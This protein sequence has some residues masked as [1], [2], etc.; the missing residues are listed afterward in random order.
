MKGNVITHN[1]S[2]RTF[3]EMVWDDHLAVKGEGGSADLIH[4]YPH[5]LHEVTDP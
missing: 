4:I 3:A 2:P 1:A 5:L